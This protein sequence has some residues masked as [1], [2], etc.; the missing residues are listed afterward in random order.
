[1]EF[2]HVGIL[3]ND[4]DK[5]LSHMKSFPNSQWDGNIAE[6]ERPKEK[7][8]VGNGYKG[9]AA[10]VTVGGIVIE[11]IQPLVDDSFHA[12]AIKSRGEGIHHVCYNVKDDFDRVLQEFEEKN[13][14]I[15]AQWESDVGRTVFVQSNEDGTVYEFAGALKA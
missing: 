10:Y 1:M 13:Y 7:M 3:V 5:T 2:K 4:L 15:I 6:W 12:D 8:I 11:I 9:K 14:Q